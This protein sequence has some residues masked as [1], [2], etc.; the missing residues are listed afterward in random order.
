ER[1][2]AFP[3]GTNVEFAR[4]VAHDL[5]ELRVW[6]R[7]VGETQ[8]CGTGACATLAVLRAEGRLGDRATV[9]VPGGDLRVAYDPDAHPSVFLTGPAEEVATARLDPSWLAARGLSNAS[10]GT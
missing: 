2:P 9:R 4:V 10:D 8:A 1:H 6:E 7:G 3:K 5:V